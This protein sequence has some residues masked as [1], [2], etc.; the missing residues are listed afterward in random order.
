MDVRQLEFRFGEMISEQQK[1]QEL[2]HTMAQSF[3][4]ASRHS[5]ED[6]DLVIKAIDDLRSQIQDLTDVMAEANGI[7]R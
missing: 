6:I 5:Q 2:L 1:T 4:A 3:D 7:W